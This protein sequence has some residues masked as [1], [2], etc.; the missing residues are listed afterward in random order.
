MSHSTV[1]FAL[2]LLV[3][4]FSSSTAYAGK[5]IESS[6][7]YSCGEHISLSLQQMRIGDKRHAHVEILWISDRSDWKRSKILTA[8]GYPV[9]GTKHAVSSDPTDQI[10]DFIIDVTNSKQPR[11]MR[12]GDPVMVVC[13]RI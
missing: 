5:E 4:H 3:L 13:K 2:L 1:F 11:A 7:Q 9:A 8:S 10:G 6:V 12:R